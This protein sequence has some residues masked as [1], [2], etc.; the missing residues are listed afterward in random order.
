MY[1]AEDATTSEIALS[2]FLFCLGCPVNVF[3]CW[4]VYLEKKYYV[5]SKIKKIFSL[6]IALIPCALDHGFTAMG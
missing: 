1:K 5:K 2:Y 3:W 4:Y 6:Q